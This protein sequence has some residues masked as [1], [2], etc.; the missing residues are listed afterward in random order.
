MPGREIVSSI[1]EKSSDEMRDRHPPLN[2]M[3]CFVSA[4]R[5]LNFSRSAEDLCVTRSA[6]SRQIRGLEEFLGLQLFERCNK[7]LALTSAGKQYF[8][9]IAPLFVELKAATDRL[10]TGRA[11]QSFRL[12]VSAT[13]NAMWLMSRLSSLEALSPGFSISF[14]TNNVDASYPALDLGGSMDA[15]IRLGRGDWQDCLFDKLFDIPIQ[16]MGAPKLIGRT[17]PFENLESLAEYDWLHYKHLPDL[18][19]Q[20]LAAAGVPELKSKKR[21][22]ILDNV[23]VASQAAADGLGL[24]P[25]YM[26]LTA[27]LIADGRV[28]CAH[29]FAMLKEESYYL[30]YPKNYAQN[31]ATVFFR[32]W[33]LQEANAPES[34]HP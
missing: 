12:N 24:I 8:E 19:P 11:E 27:P 4:A 15:A 10:V 20:W 23:A 25:M 22:I 29:S 21:N 30:L 14:I 7:N 3:L 32:N 9:A 28:A 34:V 13:F 2:A 1:I 33:L 17:T 31:P 18:W 26:P 6:I 16:I 5:T